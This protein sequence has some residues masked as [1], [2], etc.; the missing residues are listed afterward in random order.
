MVHIPIKNIAPMGIRLLYIWSLKIV[1]GSTR[2]LLVSYLKN[3]TENLI[4]SM[5]ARY[6]SYNVLLFLVMSCKVLLFL[7]MPFN[8]LSHMTDLEIFN[9]YRIRKRI[10]SQKFKRKPV[11][12]ILYIKVDFYKVVYTVKLTEK[13]YANWLID[14]LIECFVISSYVL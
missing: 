6:I 8:V 14:W 7:E 5:T 13:I 4:Q 12:I 11:K 10:S 1:A 2:F 9:V 3:K